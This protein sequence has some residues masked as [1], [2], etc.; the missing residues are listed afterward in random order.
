M[1]LRVALQQLFIFFLKICQ[2]LVLLKQYIG[3]VCFLCIFYSNEA[4]SL[5]LC[6]CDSVI[7]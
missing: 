7:L 1:K 3:K 4:Q 5:I 2:I 6:V